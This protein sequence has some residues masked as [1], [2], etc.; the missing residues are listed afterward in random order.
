MLVT[1]VSVELLHA[2][3]WPEPSPQ[4]DLER[5]E[6]GGRKKEGK[7]HCWKE[8]RGWEDATWHTD[9]H[10]D[11]RTL[12]QS[13]W[14]QSRAQCSDLPL[15]PDTLCF[16]GTFLVAV[17][18]HMKWGCWYPC[19]VYLYW[20]GAARLTIHKLEQVFFLH[21]PALFYNIISYCTAD[22]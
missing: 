13:S 17:T 14:R 2:F 8:M 9:L 1:Q 20:H 16:P 7:C 15:P 6:E 11:S 10:A 12:D 3:L 5:T 22:D 21:W 4:R 19:M 18:Q